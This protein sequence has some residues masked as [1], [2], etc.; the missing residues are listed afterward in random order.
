[1]HEGY[2]KRIN[3]ADDDVTMNV[4]I[5][6]CLVEEYCGYRFKWHYLMFLNIHS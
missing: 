4:A 6:S 5:Y 2:K 1:M 3:E